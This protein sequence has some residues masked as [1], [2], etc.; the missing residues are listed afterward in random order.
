MKKKIA[1]LYVWANPPIRQSVEQ[2]LLEA[3]PEYEI[4]PIGI[5]KMLKDRIHL[6]ALNELEVARYYGLDILRGQKK[7]AEFVVATPFLFHQARKM[8]LEQLKSKSADY[9]FTFQLQS[10][11]DTSLPAIPHFIY[12]DR[13]VL[14]NLAYPDFDPHNLYAPDWIKL[15]KTIYQNAS[16][17]FVRSSYIC[18]SLIEDYQCPPEKAVCVYAGS[19]SHLREENFNLSRYSQKNILFVG[20]NWRLKGGPELE[21]AFRL[22]L[23][24][25]PD[26]SLTIIGSAPK[27]D[28]PQVQVLGYVPLADLPPYYENASIFCLPTRYEAFGVAYIEAME[29]SLPIVATNLGAIPDFVI[30]GENGH[31]VQSG[32][33]QA[34]ANALLDLL[35]SPARCRAF[36]GKSRSI[37]LDRYN[38]KNTGNL[39]RENVL[40]TLQ[41]RAPINAA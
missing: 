32:N 33:V 29:N 16:L 9:A 27:I 4:E 38:W 20:V 36:G 12:T 25:H 34:I 41:S 30:E 24:R 35:D 7:H 15:E 39:I 31:L 28:L 3:F 2:M 17:V 37:Y 21:Q 23:E 6:M 26:A 40:N 22:V 11:F 14:S 1:F 13:T 18:R 5:G 19:N 8:V 10:L